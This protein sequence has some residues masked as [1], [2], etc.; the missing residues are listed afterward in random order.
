VEP[1]EQSFPALLGWWVKQNPKGRH[2]W[3][4]LNAANVGEKWGPD[5]IDRQIKVMR[6]QP[7]AR[8]EIFYHLRNL[9]DNPA[10]A[11]AIR[12]DYAQT[13]LVPASPWLDSNPPDK[14]NL[15]ITENRA[16]IRFQWAASGGKPAW[17]WVLQIR[18]NEVWT[19]EILPAGQTSRTFFNSRPEVIAV[20]AVDRTGNL[21]SPAV[22]GKSAAGAAGKAW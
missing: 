6:T 15:T 21:S 13:A 22:L 17:L 16:G 18:T 2:L 5:E 7:A 12:A 4:G 10:L 9:T 3:P 19:T 11:A 1:R 20:S 8:G 14:P